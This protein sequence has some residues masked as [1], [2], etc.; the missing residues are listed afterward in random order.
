M[1]ILRDES[2]RTLRIGK[3]L[4]KE[5]NVVR[6]PHQKIEIIRSTKKEPR[7]VNLLAEINI[8]EYNKH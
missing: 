7:T 3:H 6:N 4:H 8:R 2:V 5:E 1:L